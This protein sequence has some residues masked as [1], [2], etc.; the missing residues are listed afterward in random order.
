MGGVHWRTDNARSLILGEAL[1]AEILADI[2]EDANEKPEFIF[3]T[4]ARK[5][6]GEP[7]IVRI[8]GGK[9]LVDGQ[10]PKE[11]RKGSLIPDAADSEN[12]ATS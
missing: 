2:T 9:I 5:A 1:A 12:A 6:D 7:Y 3:R 4:F 8:A 11:E 10:E